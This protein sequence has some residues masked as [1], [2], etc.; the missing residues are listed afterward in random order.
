MLKRARDT[1]LKLHSSGMCQ[2]KSPLSTDGA[3]EM[4]AAARR[5]PLIMSLLH[6]LQR[7]VTVSLHHCV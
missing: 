7:S 1:L 2:I 3:P 5:L 6:S 4:I